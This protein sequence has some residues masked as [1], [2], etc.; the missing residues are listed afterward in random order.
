M[1]TTQLY[2]FIK[3]TLKTKKPTK[4]TIMNFSFIDFQQIVRDGILPDN[5]VALPTPDYVCNENPK[6]NWVKS[7]S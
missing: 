2:P 3:S 4:K 6:C 1:T 7:I 5:I